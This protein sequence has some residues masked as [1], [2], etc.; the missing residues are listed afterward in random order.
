MLKL[1][2]ILLHWL[3]LALVI[4]AMSGLVYIEAQQG[5]RMNANDPQVQLAED[6]AAVLAQG[7]APESIAPPAKIDVSTSL[8]PFVMVFDDAGKTLA[9][10]GMLN[11]QDPALPQG[12]LD[13]ARAHGEDRVTWTPVP[14]VRVAAVVVKAV[15]PTAGF[16][17]AGRALREV[18]S[19]I[20]QST[21]RVGAAML[22]TLF[23]SLVLVALV[24]L[25]FHRE[26]RQA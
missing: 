4:V 14:G 16:V 20:D 22:A 19:R 13:Y 9:S 26:K 10:S 24:E 5:Y 18:E 23:A 17:L 6:G 12:V 1:R 15:G 11:G 21:L 2:N 7:A 3:P 8:A 25:L